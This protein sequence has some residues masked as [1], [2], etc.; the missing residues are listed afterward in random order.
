MQSQMVSYYIDTCIWLNLFKKEGDSSK[1][2]PYWKIVKDFIDNIITTKDKIFY[3]GQII[4]EI[5]YKLADDT[6]FKA[7]KSY[8]EENFIFVKAIGEDYVMARKLESIGKNL[9]I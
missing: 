7:R 2:I 9:C 6:Q 1:G 8:L 5:R 3:S 4:N